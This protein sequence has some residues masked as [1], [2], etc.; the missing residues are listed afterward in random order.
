MIDCFFVKEPAWIGSN[1]LF[2]YS[3][4]SIIFKQGYIQLKILY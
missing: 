1:V 2:K 3:D 4:K